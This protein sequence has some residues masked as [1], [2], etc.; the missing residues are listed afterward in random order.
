M[1]TVDS[2]TT[3]PATS[4]EFSAYSGTS[5]QFE[6]TPEHNFLEE[7]VHFIIFGVSLWNMWY[8]YLLYLC[9]S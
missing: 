4:M 1:Y 9:E 8:T 5:S 6:S 7:Y 2:T 3:S